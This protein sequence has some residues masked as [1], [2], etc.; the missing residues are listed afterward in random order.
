MG[1]KQITSEAQVG[2]IL[3]TMTMEVD[4]S[5]VNMNNTK[6]SQGSQNNLLFMREVS[7]LSQNPFSLPISLFFHLINIHFQYVSFMFFHHVL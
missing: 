2:K 7:F 4:T 5:S 1:W 6:V 3:S